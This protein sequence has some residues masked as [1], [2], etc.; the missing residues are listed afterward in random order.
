MRAMNFL[1]FAATGIVALQAQADLF[2]QAP[3]DVDQALRTRVNKFYQSYVDGK[4]RTAMALVAED[5]QDLW[6][7]TDKPKYKSFE[8]LKI[9]YSEDF[10]NA[11]VTVVIEEALKQRIGE[12]V[13]KVP[14]TT[15]WRIDDGAWVYYVAKEARGVK[16]TPFGKMKARPGEFGKQIGVGRL[17][18]RSPLL[19]V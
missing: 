12:F 6:F 5:T 3:P 15:T 11:N 2:R 19:T 14:M 18:D 17:T 4:P 16:D 7:D 8:L 9:S 10:R 1:F 13:S